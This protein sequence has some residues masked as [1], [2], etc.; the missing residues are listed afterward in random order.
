[1][2]FKQHTAQF[3][4]ILG[5]YICSCVYVVI[6]TITVL[7][8]TSIITVIYFAQAMSQTSMHKTDG[9]KI[10]HSYCR[11]CMHA[12]HLKYRR[13]RNFN[14]SYFKFMFEFNFRIVRYA[15]IIITQK[16]LFGFNF[17]RMSIYENKI[18]NYEKKNSPMVCSCCTACTKGFIQSALLQKHV[19]KITSS[20]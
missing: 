12:H 14:I 5:L 11:I 18:H 13:E 3:I 2:V 15:C 17:I 16:F 6:S 10:L 1:M 20:Y 4:Y 19:E 8:L 7:L 9:K